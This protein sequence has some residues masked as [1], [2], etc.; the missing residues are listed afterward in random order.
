MTEPISTARTPRGGARTAPPRPRAARP[1]PR[2]GPAPPGRRRSGTPPTR[3][4]RRAGWRRT[5]G[6]PGSQRSRRCSRS[7]PSSLMSTASASASIS[8]TICRNGTSLNHAFSVRRAVQHELLSSLVRR[9]TD[10][11]DGRDGLAPA[12]VVREGEHHDVDAPACYAS[13]RAARAEATREG[14]RGLRGCLA[15]ARSRPAPDRA[16]GAPRAPGAPPRGAAGGG[17]RSPS[18]SR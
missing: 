13:A 17:R 4:H 8:R 9:R 15:G 18:R 3:C 14:R 11:A 2:P 16:S 6:R 1:R 5:P 10:R 12:G 7:R